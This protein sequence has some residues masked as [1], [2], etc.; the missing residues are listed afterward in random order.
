[1]RPAM[2]SGQKFR[3]RCFLVGSDIRQVDIRTRFQG[4][5]K[6][7][8]HECPDRVRH[9]DR[10]A[11]LPAVMRC[12]G[13][14]SIWIANAFTR[15]VQNSDRRGH[16]R[17]QYITGAMLN[18]DE[19]IDEQQQRQ[20]KPSQRA[21][22]IFPVPVAACSQLLALDCAFGSLARLLDSRPP[23]HG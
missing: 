8:L 18:P 11:E 12:A 9:H 20:N 1:M 16:V 6:S 4:L 17:Y 21:R 19:R 23:K 15:S 13:K 7:G 5:S 2:R 3:G 22:S 14:L 10:V